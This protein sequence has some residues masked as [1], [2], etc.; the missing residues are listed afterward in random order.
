MT[1]SHSCCEAW[2][3]R[4]LRVCLPAVLRK[5]VILIWSYIDFGDILVRNGIFGIIAGSNHLLLRCYG[6][7][8]WWA[9]NLAFGVASSH[10]PR[11]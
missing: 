4:D 8:L 10:G 1:S 5:A 3:R 11:F 2:E 6:M 9:Y 7:V